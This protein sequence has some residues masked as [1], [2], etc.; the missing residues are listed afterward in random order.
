MLRAA[1]PAVAPP[2]SAP[3]AALRSRGNRPLSSGGGA[4]GD[5]L[6]VFLGEANFFSGSRCSSRAG[7]VLQPFPLRNDG[8]LGF[9][10]LATAVYLCHIYALTALCAIESSPYAAT[11]HRA[12]AAHPVGRPVGGGGLLAALFFPRRPTAVLFAHGTD[13]NTGGTW[14]LISP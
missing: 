9:V 2:A 11:A 6:G 5:E 1:G 4:G 12:A 14:A 8:S 10:L 3:Y 13:A 7:A